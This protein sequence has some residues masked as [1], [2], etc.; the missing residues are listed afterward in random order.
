MK[1]SLILFD[2]DD[3]LFDFTK[4]ERTAFFSMLQQSGAVPTEEIFKEYR[5]ISE[6][7][8]RKFEQGLVTKEQVKV[9]RYKDLFE[10]FNIDSSPVDAAELYLDLLSEQH[11]L[12]DGALELC[13]ELANQTRVGIVTNGVEFV[14]KRRLGLSLIKEHIELLIVSEEC[15]FQKP[16]VRIFDYTLER[17]LH[18]DRSKVLMVGDRLETDVLGGINASIAT[19]WYNHRQAVNTSS[20]RPDFEVNQLSEILKLV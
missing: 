11:H 17:A 12:M 15:G 1:Y 20:I 16:D 7:Y 18:T 4:G 10:Q 6:G 2:A 14:Q 5:K 8:W 9:G 13:R 3:T 19:C